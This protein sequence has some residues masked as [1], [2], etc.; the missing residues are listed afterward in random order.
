MM[1]SGHSRQIL[2]VLEGDSHVQIVHAFVK[3]SPLYW[4][5]RTLRLAENMRLTEWQKDPSADADALSFLDFLRLLVKDASQVKNNTT[6]HF[7]L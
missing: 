5:L 3:T 6:S 7:L 1:F 2:P 4:Q